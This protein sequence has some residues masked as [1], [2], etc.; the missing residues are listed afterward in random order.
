M[1]CR[2]LFAGE[3]K[4]SE[5]KV[6]SLRQARIPGPACGVAD[7]EPFRQVQGPEHVEGLVERELVETVERACRLLQNREDAEGSARGAW[8][9]ILR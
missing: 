6:A 1:G 4:R 5:Q 3:I 8:V 9:T 2:S 7:P